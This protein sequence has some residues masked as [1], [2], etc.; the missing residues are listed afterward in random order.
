MSEAELEVA[1]ALAEISR[2]GPVPATGRGDMAVGK[3]LLDLLGIAQTTTSKPRLHGITLSARRSSSRA[4]ANRVNL[5]AMVPDWKISG[6]KSSAEIVEKYGYDREGERRLFVSVR[7][8]RPNVQGLFLEVD[9]SEGLLRERH[10]SERAG[11]VDEVAAWTLSSLQERLVERHPAS[12]W[13]TANS[14]R[15]EDQ[16]Y[17]HYRYVQ[18][19]ALPRADRL[20]DLLELGTVTVDHLIRSK[21]GRTAEQGPLFKI[22]PENVRALFPESPRLD[23]MTL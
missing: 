1:R 4:D 9:R 12:A 18:F 19:T 21:G 13:I 20:T 23:L 10:S 17:F 16:E 7:A 22:R 11:S 5:F 14:T 2:L 8:G 3:T 15:R 6:C